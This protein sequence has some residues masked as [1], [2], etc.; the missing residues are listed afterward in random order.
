MLCVDC[1]RVSIMAA[2]ESMHLGYTDLRQLVDITAPLYDS[3]NSSD[4]EY[5][6]SE[7][8]SCHPRMH[9]RPPSI[10]VVGSG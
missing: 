4:D 8:S 5:L 1:E 10:P 9:S 6:V 3:E 7:N 2:V